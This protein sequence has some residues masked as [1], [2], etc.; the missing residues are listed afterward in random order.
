M[1][2]VYSYIPHKILTQVRLANPSFNPHHFWWVVLS[3]FNILLLCTL[4]NKSPNTT[5]TMG[6]L[7][8][9]VLVRNELILHGLYRLAVELSK[10]LKFAKYYINTSVHYIGGVHASAATWS[11]IWLSLD[12]Y[13]QFNSSTNWLILTTASLLTAL[14]LIIIITAT[15]PFRERF[16]NSFEKIHRYVGWSCLA[17]LIFYLLSGLTVNPNQTISPN[18]IFTDPVF[19][20]LVLIIFSISLPW[21]TV[22]KFKEFTIDCPSPK[23][24]VLTV[25]GKADVGTFA[26]IST[27]FVE[28]HSFSVAGKT[29]NWT[30]NQPQIQ[31]IIGV[32]GDW[33]G[34]LIKRVQAGSF[35]KSLWVRRVKPPGFMFSIN[36]YSRVV[37][38]ATGAG[39]APV[40]PYLLGNKHKVYVLWI[41]NNHR[42]TYGKRIW[43]LVSRY[44]Q[45]QLYDTGKLGRPNVGE[46]AVKTCHEFRAQAVFCV[47]NPPITRAVVKACLDLKIPAYG[48][49]WDS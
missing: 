26:R 40:L 8:L 39:I 13:Q 47:S 38:V 27:D 48:A 44:P 11:L 14:L 2:E 6:N 16:H 12:L 22:Q 46:L 24:A 32:S 9:A 29:F 49:S 41:G 19:W 5:L 15:P 34:N 42:E 28:W 30:T 45:I 20:M 21:L 17:L 3:I 31:L 35:P 1:S 7:C 23:V 33:T 4:Y 25:A 37:V 10:R 18:Q 43:S 36:A